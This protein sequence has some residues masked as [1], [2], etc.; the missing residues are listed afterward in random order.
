MLPDELLRMRDLKRVGINN[1]VTLGRWIKTQ[2]FPPGRYLGPNTR[3]WDAAEVAAWWH[4]RPEAE[5]PPEN[6]TAANSCSTRS[7]GGA[8][9]AKVGTKATTQIRA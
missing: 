8:M 1:W 7:D 2:G 6:A 3:V 4:S 9:T 5:P